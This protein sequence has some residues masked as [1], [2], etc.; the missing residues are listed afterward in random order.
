MTDDV[1]TKLK[2]RSNLT[3]K[4]YKNGNFKFDFAKVIAKSNECTEAISAAKDKCIKQI[5]EKLN[6]ALAAPKI[7]WEILKRLLSNKKVPC[8]TT[9]TT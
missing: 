2:E 5:S 9:T 8:H 7:Y 6:D 3:K 1:K 4:Y